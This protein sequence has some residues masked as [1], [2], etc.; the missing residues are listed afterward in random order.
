MSRSEASLGEG[1]G[2]IAHSLWGVGKSQGYIL[3]LF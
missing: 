2:G 3:I 1:S